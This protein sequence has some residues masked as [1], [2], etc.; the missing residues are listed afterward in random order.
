MPNLA[1]IVVAVAATATPFLV[2]MVVYTDSWCWIYKYQNLISGFL[3]VGAACATVYFLHRQTREANKRHRCDRKNKFFAARA[4]MLLAL[5]DLCDYARASANYAKRVRDIVRRG[6]V[7]TVEL[8]E[9]P[10]SIV[11][12]L[13][14]IIEY[15]NDDISNAVYSLI[16]DIQ[17][18]HARLRSLPGGASVINGGSGDVLLFEYA[19]WDAGKLYAYASRFFVYARIKSQEPPDKPGREAIGS[20]LRSINVDIGGNPLI[21]RLL[22]P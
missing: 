19:L 10:E 17:T 13:R 20:A 18:Q 6:Q 16:S 7:H 22:D 9:L 15:G 14:D 12:T 4:V 3:A 5:S 11:A 21:A 2:G 8:P 1:L